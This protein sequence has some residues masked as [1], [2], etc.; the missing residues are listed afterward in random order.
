M[1]Q[2]QIE[3]WGVNLNPSRFISQYNKDQKTKEN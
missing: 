3:V 1:S 2:S